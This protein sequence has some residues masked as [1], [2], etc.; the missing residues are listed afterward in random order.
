M[1]ALIA[2]VLSVCAALFLPAV[3]RAAARQGRSRWRALR[4]T[5]ATLTF[6]ALGVLLGM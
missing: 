4:F 5:I 3:C 6:V 2:T 1:T